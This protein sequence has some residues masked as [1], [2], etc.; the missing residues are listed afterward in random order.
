[1]SYICEMNIDTG[2]IKFVSVRDQE[3][4]ETSGKYPELTNESEGSRQT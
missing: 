1:M 4:N 3:A 2:F